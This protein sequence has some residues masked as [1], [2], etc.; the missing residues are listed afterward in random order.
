MNEATTGRDDTTKFLPASKQDFGRYA[1]N[2]S[3]ITDLPLSRSQEA[4][5]R[6]YG[7]ADLHAI[8]GALNHVTQPPAYED[9]QTPV[10]D[11]AYFSPHEISLLRRQSVEH[12]IREA[13]GVNARANP[14]NIPAMAANLGVFLSP[15]AHRECFR[16]LSR[17]M[18]LATEKPKPYVPLI[19]QKALFP[20][21]PKLAKGARF[22]PYETLLDHHPQI[23]AVVV[24]AGTAPADVPFSGEA[25]HYALI[26][27]HTRHVIPC[28][29]Y[30]AERGK[31]N[32]DAAAILAEYEA[33]NAEDEAT[34][35]LS[36]LRL[37]GTAEP[38]ER[39]QERVRMRRQNF[40]PGISGPSIAAASKL[41]SIRALNARLDAL[42]PGLSK[43][44]SC[45][46]FNLVN[47]TWRSPHAIRE[48]DAIAAAAAIKA[49][50]QL[51][52]LLFSGTDYEWRNSAAL[53]MH[54]ALDGKPIEDALDAYGISPAIQRNTKQLQIRRSAD[55]SNNMSEYLSVLD[56]MNR[57]A[58]SADELS[59]L[60]ELLFKA[61]YETG[62][63]E[64]G[65]AQAKAVIRTA[66]ANTASAMPH[67]PLAM[68]LRDVKL[69]HVYVIWQTFGHHMGEE[70]P[71]F[72]TATTVP[73]LFE[74]ATL[75]A[76]SNP[77]DFALAK[78]NVDYPI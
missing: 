6:I 42:A 35:A 74:Q 65:A 34:T 36:D 8:Q 66:V 13:L 45:D 60:A 49:H 33:D 72:T 58:V 27:L 1:K 20:K 24:V 61:D 29:L 38:E 57:P 62:S 53:A 40:Q 47:G 37:S 17:A 5:A 44:S 51:L 63:F 46:L 43:A 23:H 55:L 18:Q 78:Q 11:N 10:D 22:K 70:V 52:S 2:L 31:P 3:T 48:E 26:V 75:W 4:L 56:Q 32:L 50:P 59:P 67:T 73:D 68:R 54:D 14:F 39:A 30:P 21:P 9:D 69:V 76:S 15:P 25:S 16:R 19:T 77:R 41:S 28:P 64:T 7:Y 71:P 12:V